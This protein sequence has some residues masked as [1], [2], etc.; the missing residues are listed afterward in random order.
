MAN[1]TAASISASNFGFECVSVGP[2]SANFCGQQPIRHQRD[3]IA[4]GL[5]VFLF[6]FGPVI[7]TIDVAHMMAVVTIGIALKE[8][9][10]FASARPLHQLLC[11]RVDGPNILAVHAL[12]C[13]MPKAAGR[14]RISPAVVSR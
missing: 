13:G 9:R 5:P 10:T 8:S 6:L 3:R 14:G 4:L 11:R 1:W 2:A 12:R 7:G